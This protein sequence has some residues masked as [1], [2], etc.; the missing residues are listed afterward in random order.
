MRCPGYLPGSAFTKAD[1]AADK[2]DWNFTLLE[3]KPMEN[4]VEY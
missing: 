1:K 3:A 4:W 2:A